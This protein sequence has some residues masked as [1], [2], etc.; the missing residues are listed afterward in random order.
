MAAVLDK[1]PDWHVRDVNVTG[2]V[3][4]TVKEFLEDDVPTMA[5]AMTYYVVLAIFPFLL[6]LAG[7]TSVITTVYDIPD[8]TERVVE[9]AEQVLPE[10]AAAVVGDVTDQVVRGQGGTAISIGLIGALWAASN[11]INQGIR[12]MNLAYN[13]KEE[14]GMIRKRLLSLGLTIL[15]GLFILGGTALIYM[16]QGMAG[17]IG[18]WLGW[19]T[20]AV[21]LWNTLTPVLAILMLALAVAVFYWAGPNT[22]IRPRTVIPGT[23]LF[24]ASWIVF[25][26][27]FSFYL[28]NFGN[29][30]ATYGSIAAVI[31]L[32]LWL[33]WSNTLLLAGAELNAVIAKRHDEQYRAD[34]RNDERIAAA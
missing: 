19:S 26:I 29:F 10:D 25:S 22:T 7:I 34:P 17:G 16:G 33:Y 27:G 21:V 8:L 5:A 14:R 11:A 23:V 6:V 30:N 12:M 9:R 2:I 28:S 18:G 1:V 24:V 31:I 15:L 13:V 20:W 4:D 32:L 3:R